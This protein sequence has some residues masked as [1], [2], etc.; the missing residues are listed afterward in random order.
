MRA[1]NIILALSLAA[2]LALGSLPAMA[3]DKPADNMQLVREKIRADKKLFVAE[4]M[5]FTESEAKAFWP[6]YEAY[7]EESGKLW[8]RMLKLIEGY[9]KDY[10]TMSDETAKKLLDDYLGIEAEALKLKNAYLPKFRTVLSEKKV[11]RYY[12]L[13]NKVDAVLSFELAAQIPLVK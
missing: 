7:Q 4:N 1:K 9:A 11:A 5:Q 3:Q 6:I 8:D 2:V 13:E 12:Q 10:Q